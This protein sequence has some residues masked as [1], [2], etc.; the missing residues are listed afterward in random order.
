MFTDPNHI[1][2]E[3]PGSLEGNTVFTYLDAFCKPE[4]SQEFLPEYQNLDE[5]KAHCE[6][7]T[8]RYESEEIPEQCSSGRTG[9]NPQQKKRTRK[10][11]LQSTRFLK[12]KREG[13]GCC[14]TDIER[15]KRCYED[16]LF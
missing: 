10:T 8:W 9:A 13:R 2:V 7:R 1:R 3:D 5:L 16:Q 11:F 14:S 15:S 12:G 4:Y 6:R